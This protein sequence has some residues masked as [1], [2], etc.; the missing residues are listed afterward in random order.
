MSPNMGKKEEILV[1][2]NRELQEKGVS[3]LSFRELAARLGIKSSSV[4]YYFPQKDDLIEE[5]A[6]NYSATMF[7]VM[8]EKTSLLAPGRARLL[9]LFDLIA[10]N[11]D[12]RQCTAGILA[13]ESAQISDAAKKIIADFFTALGDWIRREIEAVGKTERESRMLATVILSSI[14]GSLMIDSLSKKT[15]YLKEL[16]EFVKNL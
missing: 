1:L 2:A 14:E 13:A 9:K 16:R 3:S 5:V 10:E 15:H 11:L 4:H 6:R 8:K 7:T 12:T